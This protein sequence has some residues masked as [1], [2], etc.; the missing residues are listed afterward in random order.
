MKIGETIKTV[1]GDV[2]IKNL[3]QTGK[4]VQI[5]NSSLF[6]ITE[7]W[8]DADYTPAITERVKTLEVSTN[9]S[10]KELEKVLKKLDKIV[11]G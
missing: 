3:K 4:T 6:V 2:K 11:N 5:N 8:V 9:L 10:G 1:K 7:E